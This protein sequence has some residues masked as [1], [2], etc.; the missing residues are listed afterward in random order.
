MA[1]HSK[2]ANIQHRK[3]RVDAKRAKV[4]TRTIKEVT[5][6]ARMGGGDPAGNPRLRSAI[7]EARANNV[8]N[9]TIDRAI[10]KGTGEGEGI[11]LEEITYE[12]YGPGGVA[13]LVETV[14]DNR[15]R[16]V[17]EI[18]HL[19][20]RHGGNLGDSGCVAWIFDRRGYIAID[21]ET[22]S[23]EGFLELALDLEVDDLETEDGAFTLFVAPESYHRVVDEL[24]S[25]GVESL[26]KNLV[27]IPQNTTLLPPEP[28][29]KM[30]GFLE[31][32]EDHDDVQAVWSNL[33]TDD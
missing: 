13:I 23:E 9:D 14:T 21:P 27:M 12:G 1:G 18:R 11:A 8:P 32:L 26:D 2:W 20:S 31:V 6:A 33:E 4:F 19:F 10:A 29:E 30:Q 15:N 16:T 24:E 22:L 3:A 17:A 28:A 5:V 7:Q 25:R